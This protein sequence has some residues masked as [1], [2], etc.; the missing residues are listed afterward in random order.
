MIN[1]PSAL[2]F[3]CLACC[4]LNT[5]SIQTHLCLQERYQKLPFEPHAL[6]DW[7]VHARIKT[8]AVIGKQSILEWYDTII[9]SQ[10]IILN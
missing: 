5:L 7:F 9:T 6:D 4:R 3:Q 8:L 1:P 10:A 2:F